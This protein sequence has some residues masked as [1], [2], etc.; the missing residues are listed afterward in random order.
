LKCSA[1]KYPQ[2]VVIMNDKT[3]KVL[4]SV[5]LALGGALGLAGTFA[6]SASLRGLAW[7]IDGAALVMA[8][9]LLTVYFFRLGQEVIAAGFIVFAVGEGITMSGAAMDLAASVPSF[10]AGAS[11]WSVALLLISVPRTF[12]RLVRIL[13]IVAAVLFA[14]TSGQIFA[15]VQLLPTSHP[16]PFFA[17]PVFV[18]TFVGWIWAL[19]RKMLL[20]N[21]VD[22]ARPTGTPTTEQPQGPARPASRL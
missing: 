13:G 17:Y 11:L 7:G 9:A 22:S 19:M 14:A 21:A 3:L 12:P 15:G 1:K 20:N 8:S 18:A 10:G 2:I 5:G 6:P 16:L 4:A